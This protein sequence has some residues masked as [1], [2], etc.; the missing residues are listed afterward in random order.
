M[1]R[2][3]VAVFNVHADTVEIVI[4]RDRST[5][6]VGLTVLRRLDDRSDDRT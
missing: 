1:S 2:A 6:G 5:A 4:R 3:T